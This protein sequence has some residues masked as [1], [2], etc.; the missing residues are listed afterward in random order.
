MTTRR[1]AA[2]RAAAVAFSLA[3]SVAACTSTMTIGQ[4][5]DPSLASQF[6]PGVSTVEDATRLLGPR[7]LDSTNGAGQHVVEWY[8][9]QA[10]GHSSGE[11]SAHGAMVKILFGPDGRMIRIV[12][13]VRIGA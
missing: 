12:S 10:T 5:F 7:Y 13:M 1:F 2:S 4:P 3:A 6:Q 11:A 9:T 8:Y